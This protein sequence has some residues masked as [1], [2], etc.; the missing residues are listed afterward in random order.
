MMSWLAIALVVVV[1]LVAAPAQGI[2]DITYKEWLGTYRMPV[3]SADK[4]FSE[5]N[6]W[7]YVAPVQVR[8][9]LMSF[10]STT[11]LRT[12]AQEP[13]LAIF[14][15]TINEEFANEETTAMSD[16]VWFYYPDR[17][18]W[19]NVGVGDTTP[20]A[21]SFHTAVTLLD[22][23]SGHQAMVVYGGWY[24]NYSF[25]GP[26]VWLLAPVTLT[27]GS[28]TYSWRI[29]PV[30]NSGGGSG[31][32]PNNPS[33]RVGQAAA[34]L[35]DTHMALY[36]GL[37]KTGSPASDLWVFDITTSSWWTVQVADNDPGPLSFMFFAGLEAQS[38]T[39]ARLVAMAGG[40]KDFGDGKNLVSNSLR[41][42]W[43]A[44]V[45]LA[46]RTVS[47]TNLS[48]PTSSAGSELSAPPKLSFGSAAATELG[49]CLFGGTSYPRLPKLSPEV[50]ENEEFFGADSGKLWC[51]QVNAAD[52]TAT[53]A[54]PRPPSWQ[55]VAKVAIAGNVT[56]DIGSPFAR[57]GGSL[58][59]VDGVLYVWGGE[60]LFGRTLL[61][62]L[63]AGLA[64]PSGNESDPESL[65]VMWAQV[66]T[67]ARPTRRTGQTCVSIGQ[68]MF[69]F[70]GV[71]PSRVSQADLWAFHYQGGNS[72]VPVAFNPTHSPSPRWGHTAVVFGNR[73][74]VVF[75]GAYPDVAGN[76]VVYDGTYVFDAETGGW[77]LGTAAGSTLPQARVRHVA[78]ACSGTMFV[79]GGQSSSAQY[80]SDTWSWNIATKKWSP[81]TAGFAPSPRAAAVA[82]C[83][84]N[85]IGNKE[86][87]VFSGRNKDTIFDDLWGYDTALKTWRV[88]TPATIQGSAPK[89]RFLASMA[90]LGN[91]AFVFGGASVLNYTQAY[92]NTFEFMANSRP[93]GT[94]RAIF[95]PD[96]GVPR[97]G[98]CSVFAPNSTS[99]IVYAG[100]TTLKFDN[101]E[102]ILHVQFGCNPG[103]FS[104]DFM[105]QACLPCGR[106]TY[107]EQPSVSA[108][109]CHSSCS[110]AT[111][112]VGSGLWT[113]QSNCTTCVATY[114]NNHGTCSLHGN[115]PTC[116]C[117]WMY[118]GST[119]CDVAVGIIIIGTVAGLVFLIF[120]SFYARK[121][122]KARMGRIK[123][124][125]HLQQ[126]LLCDTRMEL[127]TLQ[128]VWDVSPDDV[129]LKHQVGRGAYGE[130]WYAE[131]C[132]REVAVKVLHAALL[133]LD[134]QT[135][136]EFQQEAAFL[137]TL[138]HKN[139]V[140][141]FGAGSF[142]DEQPFIVLEYMARGSLGQILAN[143]RTPLELVR[144]LQF[145]LDA[146]YGM[147]HV[148]SIGRLHRDLKSDNLLVS[149]SWVV[150]IADFGTGRLVSTGKTEQSSE[151][152]SV[153]RDK[154]R[155]M[156]SQQ[157]TLCWQAP[158]VMTGE[159]RYDGQAADVYSFGM[160]VWEILT[161]KRPFANVDVDAILQGVPKGLRPDL[162]INISPEEH[163]A[164]LLLQRCWDGS[165]SLRPGFGEIAAALE[166][167]VE[168]AQVTLPSPSQERHHK[169]E[170]AAPDLAG[171]V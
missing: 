77:A 146:A 18:A 99:G 165:A 163:S 66:N 34:A 65:S 23:V 63:W 168:Q 28:M 70:G 150:K 102:D 152:P 137:K 115:E 96:R 160:T 141:F 21:R 159:L 26:D 157:G 93:N 79:F 74:M 54:S 38:V 45:S 134:E 86:M 156:T 105:K 131:W 60:N 133:S 75:G 120:A 161:R 129:E 135:T 22:P 153:V 56:G 6:K 50:Y 71:T 17:G 139:V 91:K 14:G 101:D 82:T 32:N 166:E 114:C 55:H 81:L 126:K 138:R 41:T 122:V 107:A 118:K 143:P 147:R 49:F 142:A 25:V 3:N 8:P 89:P 111:D 29:A 33:F 94:W 10:H 76:L 169:V 113:S 5:V 85:H 35:D 100:R 132:G 36:G 112:T 68:R 109:G 140:L 164:V 4:S 78:V 83:L 108:T 125:T 121:I 155:T 158:E 149:K 130:V 44:N 84:S 11:S 171:E 92:S 110:G 117:T 162:P 127:E 73:H 148:H 145:A 123:Q 24:S 53:L 20:E 167:C 46:E 128:K 15:G 144:K 61:G 98:M 124:Y 13:A 57:V 151:R 58:T 37:D 51:V 106:G 80:L 90:T 62:T 119:R 9:P 7:Q 19:L 12:P 104:S 87:F 97:F 64:R 39:G 116:S 95:L 72:W 69:V 1:A 43:L 136:V 170:F 30:A 31:S 47:W 42:V 52:S 59:A 48:V 154:W 27:D 67:A 40:I 16:Q 88:V 2:Q 103:T